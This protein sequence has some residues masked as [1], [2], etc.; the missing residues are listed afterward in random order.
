MPAAIVLLKIRRSCS[1]RLSSDQRNEEIETEIQSGVGW[2]V[3]YPALAR[4][5]ARAVR[6]VFS[7][8]NVDGGSIQPAQ[9]LPPALTDAKLRRVRFHDLRHTFASLLLQQG[10]ESLVYVKDQM[11]HSSIQITVDTYGHTCS[12]W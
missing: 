10:G 12:R 6:N 7:T 1:C 11:G 2:P 3:S 9:G 8:G 5:F 4:G